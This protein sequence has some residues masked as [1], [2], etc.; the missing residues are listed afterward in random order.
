L[1]EKRGRKPLR[2]VRGR[3]SLRFA[4][5]KLAGNAM[6]CV[7]GHARMAP[8]EIDRLADAMRTQI[9][10]TLAEDGCDHYGFARD[11]GDPDTLI[12]SERWRD[13]AAIEAHFKAP[14]MAV[15]NAALA[16]AQVIE[17]SVKG[18]GDDGMVRVLMG[19]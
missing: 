12:I 18:Y 17:V 10:A 8:G 9:A 1:F 2:E 11:V 4:T 15:F 13:W 5:S 3:L 6:I 19:G 7:M 16:G 14:H